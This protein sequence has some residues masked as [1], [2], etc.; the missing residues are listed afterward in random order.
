NTLVGSDAAAPYETTWN[1]PAAGNHTIIAR[2]YDNAGATA[3][4]SPVTITIQTAP[5]TGLEDI[6]LWASDA[7]IGGGWSVTADTIAAG[8]NRLQNP[9]A[10]AAKVTTASPTPS[11]YF[12]LTFNPI[13]GRGYRLWIRGKALQ[14]SYAN[15]SV[16]VQFEK[17][18]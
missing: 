9:N 13:P 18:L 2:A 5:S 1:T 6:V 12:E 14:N 15:D 8:G 17:S 11:R 16:H 7:T 3:Q 4:S 10:G